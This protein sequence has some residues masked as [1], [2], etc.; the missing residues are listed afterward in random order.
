MRKHKEGHPNARLGDEPLSRKKAAFRSR[1]LVPFSLHE[2]CRSRTRHWELSR[3]IDATDLSEGK[4]L[5]KT[6]NTIVPPPRLR[7]RPVALPEKL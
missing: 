1:T 4:C 3:L 6:Q 7:S 5:Q 2:E